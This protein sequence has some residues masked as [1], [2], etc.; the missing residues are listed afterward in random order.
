MAVSALHFGLIYAVFAS[1]SF[2]P[3]NTTVVKYYFA[4]IVFLSLM[5][6]IA[7]VTD[8]GYDSWGKAV[9]D[10]FFNVV[11]YMSTTRYANCDN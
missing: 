7:L 4:S 1:R 6:A 11:S 8:R 9:M 2:K 3:L 10:S 5:T